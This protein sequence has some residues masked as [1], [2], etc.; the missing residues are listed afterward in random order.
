MRKRK[1]SPSEIRTRINYFKRNIEY[2]ESLTWSCYDNTG[3]LLPARSIEQKIQ[4]VSELPIL[5][6]QLSAAKRELKKSIYPT[7]ERLK[8][9]TQL[10]IR[11]RLLLLLPSFMEEV[12][13]LKKFQRWMLDLGVCKFHLTKPPDAHTYKGED[14]QYFGYI[15]PNCYGEKDRKWIY[16]KYLKRKAQRLIMDRAVEDR[17]P[18]GLGVQL[19]RFRPWKPGELPPR[20][21]GDWPPNSL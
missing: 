21:P 9:E 15:D 17:V 8:A 18:L 4:W 12:R 7:V 14:P 2:I 1:Q 6:E 13:D 5:R 3:C 11:E 20:Q 16:K 10:T 19:S